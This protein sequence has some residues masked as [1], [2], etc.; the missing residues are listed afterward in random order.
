MIEN[1]LAQL[2]REV[3]KEKSNLYSIQTEKQKNNENVSAFKSSSNSSTNYA[4]N[5]KFK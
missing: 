2:N 4:Y 5:S 1:K 3:F